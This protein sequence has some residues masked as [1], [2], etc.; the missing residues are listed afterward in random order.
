MLRLLVVCAVVF[1]YRGT[2][3]AVQA[4]DGTDGDQA[5]NEA[6]E[7]TANSDHRRP[8]FHPRVAEEIVDKDALV[9]TE[10]AVL[11]NPCKGPHVDIEQLNSLGFDTSMP[12]FDDSITA[13]TNLLRRKMLCYNFTYRAVS[14][15][16]Y[17]LDV[18]QPPVSDAGQVYSGQLPTWAVGGG[19]GL[20]GDLKSL[21]LAGYQLTLTLVAGEA[22]W[23]WAMPNTVKMLEVVLYKPY[24]KG[25]LA[26]RAGYEQT[27]NEF[28]GMQV[29]GN[30]SSGS[31]GV[32]AVLP[33]EVGMSYVPLTSPMV[34]V[35]AMP[36]GNFYLKGGVQRS[37]SPGGELVDLH[38]D[39]AGFR[40][41]PKGDEMLMISEAGYNR[42]ATAGNPEFWLRGGYMQNTTA[43][44]NLKTNTNTK[45]NYCAFFL[46]DRQFTQ[47]D[48]DHPDHGFYAGISGMTAPQS[49]NSY[50]RYYELRFYQNAPF[51]SRPQDMAS[52]VASYT[53]HSPYVV[54]QLL[55][56]G[57]TAAVRTGT[58]TGS[59]SYRVTRGTY[60]SSGL[61]YNMRPAIT[62]RSKGA[63]LFIVSASLFF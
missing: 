21:H 29:G 53:T 45:G 7:G 61:S 44:A 10:A 58:I 23:V 13:A 28:L 16:N 54:A 60:I 63:V 49:M 20:I 33:Y 39:A 22:N 15:P 18:R 42:S 40:F 11:Y 48:E 14:F 30:I 27:G 19:A 41:I 9:R 47:H 46:G 5:A 12:A 25:R 36:V 51:Q 52:V 57:K 24:L 2:V 8:L 1:A 31:L 35:R 37:L 43:Y 26:L 32:Y 55:A 59:Y 38:R 6:Q 4:P 50:T 17:T 56:E 3:A 62:P 34:T